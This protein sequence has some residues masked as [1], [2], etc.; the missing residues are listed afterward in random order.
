MALTVMEREAEVMLTPVPFDNVA[1]VGAAPVVPMNT[2]P[3]VKA[4]IEGTPLP[5]VTNIPLFAVANPATVFEED[6]YNNWLT[7]VV[8]GYVAVDHDGAAEALLTNIW[9][10]VPEPARIDGTPELL[11]T[12]TPLLAD[13]RPPTVLVEEE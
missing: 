11:V 7:V 12:R 1:A 6:E 9:L 5:L 10:E 13:E 2:W 3:A 8:V 4:D